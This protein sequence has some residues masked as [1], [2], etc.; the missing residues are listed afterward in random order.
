MR[1]RTNSEKKKQGRGDGGEGAYIVFAYAQ[2]S[3]KQQQ[4][5]LSRTLEGAQPGQQNHTRK[6]KNT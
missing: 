2:V 3:N 1:Q 6:T 5:V 4:N